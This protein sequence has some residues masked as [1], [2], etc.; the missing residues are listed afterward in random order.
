M[1]KRGEECFELYMRTKNMEYAMEEDCVTHFYECKGFETYEKILE[2]AKQ[3]H[4]EKVYDV[5][6]AYGHQSEIFL[7]SGVE[8][9]GVNESEIDYW[10][11]D[12]FKYISNHYPFEIQAGIKD[13]A[14]SVLCLTWNC[15]LYENEKTLQEQCEA[16]Q[17]DFRH[18]LLYMS[19]DKIDFV[20]KY[21]KNCEVIE[22]NLVYFSN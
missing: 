9:V 2:F 21:F 7:D 6:C 17:R 3:N 10:N 11:K 20:K 18:C 4:F 12:R 22:G 15:Y 19:K 1:W 14:V 16:L 5:G 8:Y 13:L